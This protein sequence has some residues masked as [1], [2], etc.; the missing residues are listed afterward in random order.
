M[1][2]H[3]CADV[4]SL[5]GFVESGVRGE[6]ADGGSVRKVRTGGVYLC[7]AEVEEISE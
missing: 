7:V 3:G 2:R 4:Y 5:T 6:N 1:L